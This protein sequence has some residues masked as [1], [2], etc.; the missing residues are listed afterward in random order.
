MKAALPR[1]LP[2]YEEECGEIV[3]DVRERLLT[4]SAATI[5]RLLQP[6]RVR[7]RWR[8]GTRA[9]PLRDEIP[10]STKAFRD[11][12]PGHI[13]VDTV[14]HCGGDMSGRF[15]WSFTTTDIVTG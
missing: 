4:V 5:D 1:W 2:G 15:L 13:E 10:I 8:G 9:T 12:R 14:A 7:D 6:Y 11:E 3:S